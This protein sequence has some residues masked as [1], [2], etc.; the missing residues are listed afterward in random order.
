LISNAVRW[1]ARDAPPP[2]EIEAPL[3]V[4]AAFYTQNGGK[5]TI[6]HLLN[7][8][9]SSANRALPENNP[10]M[11]TEVIPIHDIKITARGIKPSK[12]LLVPGNETLNITRTPRG[13]AVTV[14]KIRTHARVV[15]E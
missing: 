12:A 7:E 9:N 5:R 4:Q 13:A 14:A 6:V 1:A 10:S 11:R 8:L 2:F 15:F 3:A